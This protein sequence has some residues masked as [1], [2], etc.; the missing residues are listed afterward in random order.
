MDAA[1]QQYRQDMMAGRPPQPLQLQPGFTVGNSAPPA[2][3]AVGE[4]FGQPDLQQQQQQ[5]LGHSG[6]FHG[7]IGSGL[8]FDAGDGG[9]GPG[10]GFDEDHM[11]DDPT[12]FGGLSPLEPTSRALAA[13]VVPVQGGL[14]FGMAA[15]GLGSG[16]L[17][18][19]PQGVGSFQLPAQQQQQR[20]FNSGPPSGGGF[21]IGM[22]PAGM[23]QQQQQQHPE[24]QA[25][26]TKYNSSGDRAVGRSGS[27]IPDAAAAA[28]SGGQGTDYS[29]WIQQ[30]DITAAQT[31]PR[32]RRHQGSMMQT[33]ASVAAAGRPQGLGFAQGMV[34]PVGQTLN[35]S[36]GSGGFGREGLGAPIGSGFAV[37]PGLE[38]GG[39]SAGQQQQQQSGGGRVS[40]L[41]RLGP[42][43]NA[44]DDW[45]RQQQRQRQYEE[46]HRSISRHERKLSPAA[47]AGRVGGSGSSSKR[48]RSPEAAAVRES[49]HKRDRDPSREKESKK[50]RRDKERERRSP[51][52]LQKETKKDKKDKKDSKKDKDK[53]RS[54][55]SSR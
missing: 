44:P 48:G 28:G 13:P 32:T 33:A 35:P 24:F 11:F 31:D 23:L 12:G 34:P 3:A 9:L 51:A 22:R 26:M 8:G 39:G 29:Y 38:R 53:D 18:P 7:D 54:R 41:D 20:Q 10:L 5:P 36:G 47:A 50:E 43:S 15:G 40:V 17:N 2:A 30:G 14:G 55:S 42:G 16:S 45:D 6:A 27:G 37:P 49:K 4:S 46:Q 25:L 21:T 1:W 19:R 52:E